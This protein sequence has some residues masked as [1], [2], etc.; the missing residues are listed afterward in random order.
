M[1]LRSD[2]DRFNEADILDHVESQGLFEQ[3]SI[4]VL[5]ALFENSAHKD[6]IL[7]YLEEMNR[8]ENVFILLEGVLDSTTRKQLEK[9]STKMQEC[10]IPSVGQKQRKF[11]IFHLS[12]ALGERNRKR[13]WV[14]YQQGRMHNISPE[15]MH[16]ILFWAA[17][18]MVLA[19]QNKDAKE[20]GL[21]AYAYRNA[22]QFS[23][24]YND[25]E[26]GELLKKLVA[27]YHKARR[28][29]FPFD[30]GLERFILEHR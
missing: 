25:A 15:E 8:S 3:K 17:K 23:Q 27:L 2:A 28:G 22:K 5:D 29:V 1:V 6:F 12:D 7:E 30:I 13:M 16:G 10:A 11:N 18:N 21:S 4:V 14:I 9:Q 20:A 19:K 24:N 26:L